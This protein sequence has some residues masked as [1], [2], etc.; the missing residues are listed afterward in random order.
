MQTERLDIEQK[1]RF[2]EINQTGLEQKRPWHKI[3]KA[4][5]RVVGAL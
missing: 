2:R 4:D 1:R 5:N 3:G